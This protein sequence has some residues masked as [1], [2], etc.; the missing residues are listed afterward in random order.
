[1]TSDMSTASGDPSNRPVP[2]VVVVGAASRDRAPDDPRGWRLGGGASYCALTTASLGLAT[3]AVIGVDEPASTAREL[4]L[5]RAAGV[6]LRLVPLERGPVFDNIEAPDGR[7]QLAF[8]RADPVSTSWL[9]AEWRAAGAWILAPVAGELPD[10]WASVMSDEA[11]VALGWQ[12]L[13]RDLVPGARVGRQPPRPSAILNRADVVGVS[14]DDLEAD[15]S[16]VRL[17]RLMR[18]GAT[19]MVTRG[20]DGGVAM[21]AGGEGPRA[22]RSWPPIPPRTIVDP[23]GA[24][25]VFLA[26]Y[27]AAHAEPRLVGGRLAQG[28]DLLLAAASA[29]LAL[30]GPGLS[31]VAGREAVR[32]RIAEARR[33]PRPGTPGRH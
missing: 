8:E 10:G 7:I 5:L 31:G 9:P 28:Y 6:D 25:D 1:M 2:R 12:G 3:G 18:P 22:L 11:V 19:L 17:C 15:V 24:G 21:E 16:L 32:S 13:L 29:S 20:A 30:E 4:D 33:R 27:L 23:T 14:R 26:A